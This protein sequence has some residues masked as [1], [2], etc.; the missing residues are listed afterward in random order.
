MDGRS[1][2]K[3]TKPPLLSDPDVRRVGLEALS[4]R[5][6]PAGMIRFMRMFDAGH[7]DYTTQRHEW[8]DPLTVDDI[9]TA[10]EQQRSE[11]PAP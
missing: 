8:L 10:I 11:L 1:R 2:R 3:V 9:L 6:G 5:L 7:G 4:E